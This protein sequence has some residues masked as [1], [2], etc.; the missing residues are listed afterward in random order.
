LCICSMQWKRDQRK[1]ETNDNEKDDIFDSHHKVRQFDSQGL[2]WVR[3]TT[4]VVRTQVGPN[5]FNHT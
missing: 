1:E 5:Y 4:D 2:F 3:G